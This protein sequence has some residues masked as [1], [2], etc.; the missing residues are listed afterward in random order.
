MVGGCRPT[1]SLCERRV[2]AL[3]AFSVSLRP[4]GRL[5]AR[6][7]SELVM[8]GRIRPAVDYTGRFAEG[9]CARY[10]KG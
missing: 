8:A 4:F 3:R 10:D 2:K 1:G 5:A 7:G 9:G 6:A